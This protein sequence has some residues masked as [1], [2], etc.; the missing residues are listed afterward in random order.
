[1]DA[2]RG[3]K[4]QDIAIFKVDSQ[5]GMPA[6]FGQKVEFPGQPICIEFVLNE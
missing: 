2:C 1:M 5:T 3:Q 4:S 6:F